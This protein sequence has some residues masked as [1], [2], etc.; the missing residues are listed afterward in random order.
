M[1]LAD[2]IFTGFV[3]I[4]ENDESS[5][6]D[7]TGKTYHFP[8]RYKGILTAGTR[9]VYYKGRLRKKEFESRRLSSEAH[10][11]GFGFIGEV[12]PDQKSKK[13]DLYASIEGFQPFFYPVIS[14]TAEGFLE[15]I[16]DSRKKNYWRDGVRVIDEMTFNVIISR[17]G[18]Q[19]VDPGLNDL[20]I[21]SSLESEL[22]E[23]GVTYRFTAFYERNPV[24][25]EQ[26]LEIHGYSCFACGFDFEKVYGEHGK[27]FIE[28]H[29]VLP[30]SEQGKAVVVPKTDL[31]PLCSNCHSM[32]H[33]KRGKTLKISEL[34]SLLSKFEN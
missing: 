5:W 29:H 28:V 7:A 16:P 33:R 21:G 2:N 32:V 13:G 24:L 30:L 4:A 15:T 31:V 22:T 19:I 8:N 17:S 20:Q 10:Y 9:F 3:V 25:R 6:I 26:A 11:F 14:K 18:V 34:K 12:Y 23:G 27:G 1:T